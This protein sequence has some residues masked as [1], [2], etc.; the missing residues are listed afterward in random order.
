MNVSDVISR[1]Q[2][3]C[4]DAD[5]TYV[6][7]DM[8]LSLLPEAYDWIFNKLELADSQ[9]DQGIVVLPAVPA[10]SPDLSVYQADGQ[11]LANLLQPRML[12]WRLAGQGDL[13]W[14]RAN[15]PLAVP[16]DLNDGGYPALDSWAWSSYN[17]LLSKFS[18]DLDIEVTGDF[19]PN[20]LTG[21]DSQVLLGKNITRALS[22]KLAAEVGKRR[23]NQQWVTLYSADADEAIDD[24]TIA[25]VKARQALP[26]RVGRMNRMGNGISQL[27]Y[28]R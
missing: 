22:C 5:G 16:R 17:V 14:R 9:F 15:G 4:D 26:A 7:D 8:V 28:G 11:P 19:I 20:A 13:L 1:V 23:G 3:K 2:A 25:M 24:V 27:G 12:R 21:P 10:G 18:A 6:T